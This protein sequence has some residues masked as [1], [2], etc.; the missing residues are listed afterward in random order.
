[1]QCSFNFY[2]KILSILS[3]INCTLH[4][5]LTYFAADRTGEDVS[6]LLLPNRIK[7][8]GRTRTFL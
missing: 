7:D 1:M 3:G 8:I 6:L 2:L 5:E 4:D